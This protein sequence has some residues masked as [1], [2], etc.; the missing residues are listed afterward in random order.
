[1]KVSGAVGPARGTGPNEIIEPHVVQPTAATSTV[2]AGAEGW[3]HGTLAGTAGARPSCAC[4]AGARGRRGFN[5][6][7]IPPSV[8]ATP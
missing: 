8:E 1:M 3:F 2:V 6:T 5:Q 7:G 4:T